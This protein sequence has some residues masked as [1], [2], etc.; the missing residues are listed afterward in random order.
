MSVRVMALVWDSTLEGSNNRHVMV[1]L[2]D[3]ADETGVCWPSVNTLAR[4][5]GLDRRTVQRVVSRMV[6][7][8]FLTKRSRKASD[9]DS[10]TNAYRINLEALA[11]LRHPDADRTDRSE[12]HR[13]FDE[14][15]VG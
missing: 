3:R 15:D 8:G 11:S 7:Q 10:D 5:T 4:K 12:V 2:A 1:A 14:G 13:L 6:E 9:G